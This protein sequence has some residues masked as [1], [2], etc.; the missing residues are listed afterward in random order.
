MMTMSSSLEVIGK[1]VYINVTYGVLD[2]C[3]SITIV[4]S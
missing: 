3:L 2:A 1:I 4:C